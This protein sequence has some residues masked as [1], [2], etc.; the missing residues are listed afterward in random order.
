MTL[1]RERSPLAAPVYHTE[2][3]TST[4]DDARRL[5]RNGAPS[6]TV[7]MT[8][9]QT[10]GRGRR[11]GRAWHSAP[12]ESLMFTLALQR[13]ENPVTRSLALAA[14]LVKVLEEE[15]G[16]A[17][18]VKWPNDVL[19]NGRKICGI[20]ADYDGEWLYLGLGLNLR[21][22]VLPDEIAG[23]ATSVALE[24]GS[25]LRGADPATVP[26]AWSDYRDGVLRSL[27]EWYVVVGESWHEV[28]SPR[29]RHRGEEVE[30]AVPGGESVRGR[31]VGIARDGRL[32]LENG[33]VHR[34][35]A[36]EVSLYR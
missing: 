31:L 4:M 32:M 20:L 14:A 6:G 1:L 9:Y 30:V 2:E 26:V 24:R 12:R 5:V 8:D 21:Q 35:A 7:V 11:A 3:T 17:A 36:G 18:E 15:M 13:P 33:G 16:L 27:L 34:V 19:V 22:A 28:L 29:L 25:A 23:L 10:S